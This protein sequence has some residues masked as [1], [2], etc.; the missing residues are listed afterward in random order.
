MVEGIDR[1]EQRCKVQLGRRSLALWSGNRIARIARELEDA[2]IDLPIAL[3]DLFRPPV[4]ERLKLLYVGLN[5]FREIRERE[6]EEVRVCQTQH[7]GAGCLGK[8]A[9]IHERCIAEVREPVEV[10]VDGMIDAAIILSAVP[11]IERWDAQRVDETR[12]VRSG[13]ESTN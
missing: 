6:G 11:E 4:A 9:A 8:R 7:R 1:V 3:C 12:V 13:P 10:V 2:I 5:G